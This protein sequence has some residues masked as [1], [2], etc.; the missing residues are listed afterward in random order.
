MRK[1]TLLL[2][3]AL[4]CAYAGAAE[5]IVVLDTL[6]EVDF[7]VKTDYVLTGTLRSNTMIYVG[8]GAV[9][10][11]RNATIQGEDVEKCRWAG[12][13]IIGNATMILEG[14][15]YVRGY[16]GYWPGIFVRRTAT[17]RIKGDGYLYAASNRYG[18]GIGGGASWTEKDSNM[19]PLTSYDL[20]AGNILIE[21][22]TIKAVGADRSPG[23]GAPPNSYHG[24][25]KITSGVN[26]VEV[27]KGPNAEYFI[28]GTGVIS[29]VGHEVTIG[30]KNYGEDG[31]SGPLYQ[32]TYTYIPWTGNLSQLTDDAEVKDGSTITGNL[33]KPYKITIPDGAHI[34]LENASIN[35]AGTTWDNTP[36]GGLNCEGDATI[37][38]TGEETNIIYGIGKGYPAIHVPAGKTLHLIGDGVLMAYGALWGAGIGG[39]SAVDCGNIHIGGA[40]NIYAEGGCDYA[41]G[42][43]G[44]YNK[45]NGTI[46]IDNTVRRVKVE[47]CESASCT[48]G[49]GY[50]SGAL[51]QGKIHVG[52]RTYN[53]CIDDNPFIYVGTNQ[54]GIEETPSDS[55]SRGEKILRDGQL[56]IVV[57]DKMYDARGVEV[58]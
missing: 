29:D 38:I 39:G 3:F 46:T 44:G 21:G 35:P 42:I 51:Q 34:K 4:T 55:P 27:T 23:I 25:I 56:F 32:R 30:G 57:G 41:A 22:G 47:T 12:I 31:N 37:E 20:D 8:E 18:A 54:Q 14:N 36:F 45:N 17:L 43:G 13:E 33:T 16:N 2:L 19:N 52:G 7:R 5:H 53:G 24:W 11:L 49:A 58:R 26:R 6:D 50:G 9:F 10:T 28:G 1:F 40:L 15:N 48:V